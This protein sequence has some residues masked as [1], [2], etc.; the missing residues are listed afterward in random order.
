V[1]QKNNLK[2]RRNRNEAMWRGGMESSK[3]MRNGKRGFDEGG[4][5]KS[6]RTKKK[7][8]GMNRRYS[9]EFYRSIF[10]VP[11][12]QKPIIPR[13]L[14]PESSAEDILGEMSLSSGYVVF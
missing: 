9:Y 5:Y 6:K 1:Q 2:V 13:E 11:S 3:A 4:K 7:K 12:C 14:S 8:G 10:R